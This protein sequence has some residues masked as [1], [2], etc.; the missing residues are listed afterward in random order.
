MVLILLIP[1]CKC[2]Y[3]MI[4]IKQDMKCNVLQVDT[5]GHTETGTTLSVSAIFLSN[6]M[7]QCKFTNTDSSSWLVAIS[8]DGVTPS[9]KVPFLVSNSDCGTC[10]IFSTGDSFTV[11]CTPNVSSLFS[12]LR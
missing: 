3:L 4:T 5:S 12:I 8:N 6:S 10:D 9:N 7:V 1:K 2:S 11:T